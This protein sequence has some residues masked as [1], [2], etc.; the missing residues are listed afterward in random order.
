EGMKEHGWIEAKKMLEE[1][2]PNQAKKKTEQINETTNET[3]THQV[4]D[5]VQLLKLHKKGIITEKID[6][7]TYMVKVGTKKV[8]TKRKELEFI[9]QPKEEVEKPV[10]RTS[11]TKDYVPAELDLRGERYE[12]ALIRVE[13]YIDDCVLAGLKTAT[14]IHG[15][16]TGAL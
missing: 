6:D 12:D 13:K 11:G 10:T 4:G 1:A 14:I 5:E 8:K 9:K 3:K 15:K 7:R 16:G 2:Q